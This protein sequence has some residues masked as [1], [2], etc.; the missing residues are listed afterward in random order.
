MKLKRVRKLAP[1]RLTGS[2]L[3]EL[4][5]TLAAYARYYREEHGEPITLWPLV[6]QMLRVFVDG[7]R[8]FQ[9]WRRRLDDEAACEPGGVGRGTPLG[10]RN[11]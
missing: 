5:E 9:T 1:V 7:D 6:V 4:H 11:A 2:V 8:L 10:S 3:G